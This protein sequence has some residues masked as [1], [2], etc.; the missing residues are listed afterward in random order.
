VS[1]SCLTRHPDILTPKEIR[2]VLADDHVMVRIGIRCLLQRTPDIRVVGEADTAEEA[3]ALTAE[4]SP[5]VLI[6]DWD[7]PG[8]PGEQV[9]ATLAGSFPLVKVLVLTVALDPEL[10][11]QVAVG[12]GVGV[13]MPLA[14]TAD[15]EVMANTIRRL[16][17]RSTPPG[18]P[19]RE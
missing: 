10:C 14:K 19:H 4:L 9:L 18:L 15:I 1:D 13:V 16:A 17:R 8:R 12:L 7:M 5:D 11:G 2:V 3:I 6:W